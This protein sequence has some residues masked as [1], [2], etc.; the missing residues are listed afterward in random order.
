MKESSHPRSLRYLFRG[1]ALLGA[2]ALLWIGLRPR[3]V[4][5][6]VAKVSRGTFE[7]SVEEDGETRIRDPY[8]ISAPLF[9]R[10]LRVELEPGD[11]VSQG[12]V[13]AMIDPGGPRLLD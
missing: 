11:L 7:L 13:I 3:P 10:L 5:V 4:E 12:Q 9:G 1:A 2:V 8:L 6:D